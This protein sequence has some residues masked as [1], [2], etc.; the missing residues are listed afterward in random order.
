MWKKR[1]RFGAIRRKIEREYL[2]IT[3]YQ[4]NEITAEEHGD[5]ATDQITYSQASIPTT[6]NKRGSVENIV[7]DHSYVRCNLLALPSATDD[8]ILSCSSSSDGESEN[9]KNL[10]F[11]QQIQNWAR[12]RNITQVALNDLATIINLR[13]PGILPC[14]ARTIL[15]TAKQI[16]IKPIQGGEYWH[17]GLT[18]PLKN[19]LE[20]WVDVP[21]KICL[22]FNFDGLPI[23]NSSNKEFWPILCT[24]FERPDLE[25]LVIGIYFGVGKPKQID[26]YLNDFVNE[27]DNLIKNGMY[28][29]QIK[30]KVSIG[31]RCFI[32][33][34]PARAYI[35]GNRIETVELK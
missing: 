6:S 23:F 32:C 33:D 34:S 18:K 9:E 17:N 30:S 14:D 11:R 22:N 8:D 2:N 16:Q 20:K 5:I 3:N 10:L 29:E 1:K 21:S 26:E 12:E 25:P 4:Q 13:F 7:N 35:K 31:I 15:G 24:I 19:I 28:V 27:I